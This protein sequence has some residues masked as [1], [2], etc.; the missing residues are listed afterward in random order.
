LHRARVGGALCSVL[1][2]RDRSGVDAGHCSRSR[3]DSARERAYGA[4]FVW[5]RSPTTAPGAWPRAK[6][7]CRRA[8]PGPAG[9]WSAAS[10]PCSRGDSHPAPEPP[11]RGSVRLLDPS[12]RSLPREATPTLSS[13]RGRL[14]YP[15]CS[16][17]PRSPRRPDDD[18]LH[19]RPQ[20]RRP[21]RRQPCRPLGGRRLVPCGIRS[22]FAAAHLR[23]TG[24]DGFPGTGV[25]SATSST[26]RSPAL[27]SG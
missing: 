23:E 24:C 12:L 25:F 14:R 8:V 7:A 1:A 17:T 9:R 2:R 13:A 6:R 5:R 20:S 19:A 4:A 16:R 26:S 10:G 3:L 15:Y 27:R 11:N 21:R 22:R 18:G